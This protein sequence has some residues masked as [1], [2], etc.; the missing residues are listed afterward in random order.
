MKHR[1]TQTLLSS[2]R[3]AETQKP[4]IAYGVSHIAKTIMRKAAVILLLAL[5]FQLSAI[6]VVYASFFVT[7]TAGLNYMTGRGK[8]MPT[9]SDTAALR[10]YKGPEINISKDVKNMRSNET[11]TEIVNALRG[12]TVEFV[13]TI[14]NSGDDDGKDVVI[15][16][17]V[18]LGTIYE[19]GSA[20]DTTSLDPIDP[21][22]TIVFQHVAGGPFDI[23]DRGTITAI[24][25]IWDKIE[26]MEQGNN[27]R[28]AKFRVKLQ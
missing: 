9:V 19:T 21:P 16:D 8:V 27:R 6:T 26:N 22:D 13:L 3:S 23:F 10:I 20:S 25:W 11:S 1:L 24:K 12:D 28:V 2:F 14:L 18:P 17:S 15:I 5:S 4:H 7:N